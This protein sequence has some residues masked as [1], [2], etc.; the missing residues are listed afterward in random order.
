MELDKLHALAGHR[1][2]GG[3]FVIAPYEDWLLRDAVLAPPAGDD[4]AHPLWAF[5]APQRSMG[6]TVDEVFTLCGS[7][8]AA[9]PVLGESSI[10]VHEPLRV[11]TPYAVTGGI[12]DAARKDGRSGTFDVVR[13]TVTA[14]RDGVPACSLTNAFVFPRAAA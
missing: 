3:S 4:L 12:V 8:A 9:G 14:E 2:P 13:F 7:S 10:R 1:F 5:V 11:A 6:I